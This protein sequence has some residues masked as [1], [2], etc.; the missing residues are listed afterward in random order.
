MTRQ[1]S[2]QLDTDTE[3]LIAFLKDKGF[4]TTTNILRTAVKRMAEE[5]G[6]EMTLRRFTGFDQNIVGGEFTD[7]ELQAARACG[8]IIAFRQ[9]L[10]DV[11]DE[12]A[13]NLPDGWVLVHGNATHSH[14]P[15]PPANLPS[16]ILMGFVRVHH[17]DPHYPVW[18]FRR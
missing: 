17:G 8:S 15:T 6:F 18:M 14:K 9:G 7:E 1:T 11:I 3:A 2:F 10:F 16:P 12:R 13:A 5:E 4:G